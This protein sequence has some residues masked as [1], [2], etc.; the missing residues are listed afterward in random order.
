MT[1]KTPL[2]ISVLD[3]ALGGGIPRGYVILLEVD[4]G[5][6]SD[7]FISTFMASGL[8]AGEL[9]YILCTEFPLKFPYEQLRKKGIDVEKALKAK[10]LM[11]IDAFTDA[12]GWGEFNPESKFIVH[13]L[14]NTRHVH[15]TIRKA[16]LAMKP[17]A[18]LR[19]VVDSLTSILHA[20]RDPDEAITYVHH[21]VSAQKNHG[22]ILLYTIA[23]EAHDEEDIRR[24]EHIVDGVIA[25]YKIYDDEGW[26]IT[27]QIEKMRGI[28][29]DPKLYLYEVKDGEITLSPFT[30]YEE[31]EEDEE[32]DDEEES[33]EAPEEQ[34]SVQDKEPEDAGKP[35]EADTPHPPI[36]PVP[37]PEEAPESEP[38]SESSPENSS[39][40][41]RTPSKPIIFDE[42][43]PSKE[44]K[45]PA[46]EETVEPEELEDDEEDTFFF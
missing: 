27:C 15:D 23:R 33:E 1:D 12:Y 16:V 11:G 5:T 6:R 44:P 22:N 14:S 8:N 46:T 31:E 21:Q 7:A 36:P 29:F 34:E 10:Q 3:E 42:P 30:E 28:D 37:E 4:A 45:E 20:A 38:E 35:A 19:G 43:K 9:A 25:L 32:A 13:E 24:L 17:K 2:G 41:S 26:Q 39:R 18:N 40:E